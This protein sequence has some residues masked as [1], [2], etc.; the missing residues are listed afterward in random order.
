MTDKKIYE[1]ELYS[2]AYLG[3]KNRNEFDRMTLSEYVIRMEAYQLQ[4]AQKLE[5]LHLQAFLNQTVQETTGSDKHPKPKYSSFDEFFDIQKAIDNIRGTFERDYRP[6]DNEP[7]KDAMIKIR[8]QRISEFNRMLIDR[9]KK[10][11]TH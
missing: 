3:V 4:Q 10:G 5:C 6:E 2:Y 7:E 11:G 1:M 9:N 8:A